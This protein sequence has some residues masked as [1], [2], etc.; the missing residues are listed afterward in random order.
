MTLEQAK[1]LVARA[2]PKG[3]REHH[4]EQDLTGL[5][6]SIVAPYYYDDREKNWGYFCEGQCDF[7]S[8]GE[9]AVASS[10]VHRIK[11]VENLL[12]TIGRE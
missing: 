8:M 2:T 6:H 4:P 1:L 12:F 3:S 11:A 7:V 10:L 9:E 5:I